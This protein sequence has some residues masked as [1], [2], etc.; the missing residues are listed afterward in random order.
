[1]ADETRPS[2]GVGEAIITALVT[3]GFTGQVRRVCGRDTPIPLGAAAA[4][5]LLSEDQIVD[6]AGLVASRRT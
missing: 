3:G 4:H 1:M 6:A 2:G 5:V